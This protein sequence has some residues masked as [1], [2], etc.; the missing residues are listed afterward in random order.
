MAKFGIGQAVSRV[1]DPRLLTGRGRY[2]DDINRPG[3]ATAFVLRSPHAHARIEAIDASAASAAPGVLAV[4]SGEDV[5]A[6]GLGDLPCSMDISNR[7]GTPRAQVPRPILAQGRVRHVGEPVALVVA[8]SPD[9]ARDAAELIEVDYA[10]LPV[11]VDTAAAARDGAPLVWDHVPGNICFDWEQG[12]AAAV[13]AGIAGAAHVA[14]LELVNNRLVVNSMEPR[15]ALADTDAV[16][17]RSTL[18]T[19][20]QTVVG[21]RNELAE[22]VLRL[23]PSRLR[24]VSTDVGGGFGMKIFLYPEQCLVVWASRR[25]GRPVKWT[26]ERTEAFM[27][28]SQG[29]DNVSEAELGLDQDGRFLALRVTTYAALGAYLSGAGPFVPTEA[30]TNMLVGLYRTSAVYVNVKG[31]FTNTVPVDAYRGAGR[32]EAAYLV[33][34]L[35]D[36]AARETGLT[37]DEIRRR[38]FIGRFPYTTPL[39]DTYDSGDFTALMEA[40]MEAAAWSGAEARRHEAARRGRLGGIGMACYIEKCGGGPAETVRL[41]F[42][43]DDSVAIYIGN[44]SNGQGH[45]TAYAQVLS[46]RLGIDAASIRL[47]QGDSDLVE[48]GLTGGSRAL[49]VGGAAILGAAAQVIEK[50]RTVAA[51]AMEAAA[52]DIEFADGRFTVAGTDR[53]MTVFEAAR[54]ARDPANLAAGMAPGLDEVHKRQPEAS[55]FPNGCHICE[56][57]V[58]PDTGAV[59]ITRYTVVD[60]FGAVINPSLLAGQVH[61]GIVQGVG[62]ALLEHTVYDPATGQ[63]LSGSFTDYAL[64]RADDVLEFD[65]ATRNVPCTTNPLGIK[66]A[67][68]AGA[69]GA[70]PAVINA[71]VDAMYRAAGIAHIDMP[72]TPKRIWD[73]L[74]RN[75]TE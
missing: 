14:R 69:I 10:E 25:L 60:D 8:E 9:Q 15:A 19:P 73:A 11:I 51:N 12:D 18:Y 46:D 45:E 55:T 28:D 13:E 62:Q 57:E 66:G 43:E 34:R 16:S 68:E 71:L 75:H 35:V 32:P 53:S 54:A 29:R 21:L 72:A 37:P 22:E 50:G 33:E 38:N 64:P 65:F 44:Q 47:V 27:S 3:Q 20:C 63:L 59:A 61:G 70:P 17:G 58:D 49:S 52:A 5:A 39:G 6:D 7:D 1:E 48:S 31:V 41:E 42:A 74:H 24:V 4:L 36:A 56:L 26:S 40:C 30:G 2:T 23:D 67:G